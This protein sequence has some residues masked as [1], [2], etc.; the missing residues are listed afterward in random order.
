MAP[1][2][3]DGGI[4]SPHMVQVVVTFIVSPLHPPVRSGQMCR[5]WCDLSWLYAP[6]PRYLGP[7]THSGSPC[8]PRR[9]LLRGLRRRNLPA[10]SWYTSLVDTKCVV[11]HSLGLLVVLVTY[12]SCTSPDHICGLGPADSTC[13]FHAQSSSGV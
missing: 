3:Y 8:T 10:P 13:S 11:S 5:M 6:Q 12:W 9:M 1:W 7:G 4:G 2:I